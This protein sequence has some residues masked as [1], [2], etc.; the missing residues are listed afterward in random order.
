MD[1]G[2]GEGRWKEWKG[3]EGKGRE[4]EG[5]EGWKVFSFLSFII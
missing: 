2:R 3:R 4:G 5:K 1:G